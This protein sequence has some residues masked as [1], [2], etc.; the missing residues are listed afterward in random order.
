MKH[1]YKLPEVEHC[2]ETKKMIL[3]HN[4]CLDKHFFFFDKRKFIGQGKQG[5]KRENKA[6][7][8]GNMNKTKLALNKKRHLI[9]VYI[10]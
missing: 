7:S 8:T 5:Y 10:G 9:F 1:P 2:K 4:N 6:S 3:A